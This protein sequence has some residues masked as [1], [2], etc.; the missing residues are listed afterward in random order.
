MVLLYLS[1]LVLVV[2]SS[3]FVSAAP[4]GS[5][6]VGQQIIETFR[7]IFTPFFEALLNTSSFDDFFFAKVLL[8]LLIFV[9]VLGVLRKIDLFNK[10]RGIAPLV[11]VLISI[12]S[13]R[14][15]P[16]EFVGGV[17]LPY[18]TLGIAI[19]TFLPFLIYFW[20]VH[21]SV[22][23]GF[24]RRIAW[25]LYG[26][27][28][29]FIWGSRPAGEISG[30]SAWLYGLGF[31][32]IVLSL[33]FDKTVNG[34]FKLHEIH[35]GFRHARDASLANLQEEYH[36]LSS[37]SVR[38]PHIERRLETLKKRIEAEGANVPD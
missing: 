32:A 19:T 21:R 8:L 4:F 25:I 24:G 35:T 17:L 14:Y 18:S 5:G 15:M 9:V 10:P 33:F 1:A 20:F 36:R 12:L 22:E 27:I 11:S 26:L 38:T 29:L 23:S 3:F 13:V 34:Y 31:V 28:F 7:E 16:Q 2:F 37:S 6:E 30:S